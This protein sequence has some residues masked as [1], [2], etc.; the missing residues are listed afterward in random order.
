MEDAS[1]RTYMLEGH[2]LP[3]LGTTLVQVKELIC[4]LELLRSSIVG[5][6]RHGEGSQGLDLHGGRDQSSEQFLSG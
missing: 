5:D 1:G 3:V 4:R 6:G 2:D